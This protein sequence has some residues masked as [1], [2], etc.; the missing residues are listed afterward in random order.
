MGELVRL[1]I[2]IVQLIW[3]FRIVHQWERAGYYVFGRWWKEVGPGCWPVVPWFFEVREISTAQAIVGTG[4]LDITLADERM[5]SFA[6]SANVRV[7]DT[8]LAINSVD[9]YR[10]TAQELLCAV[11]ADELAKVETERFAPNRRS[12]L[13]SSLET[14]LNAEAKE[15]GIEFSKVRFKSFVVVSR[16]LRL[17]IDQTTADTW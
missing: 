14:A 16:V 6:A 8:N 12:R 1:V 2:E 13:L 17:L 7:V 10:Q 9:E 5:L 15:F 11:L 3:P 4:R